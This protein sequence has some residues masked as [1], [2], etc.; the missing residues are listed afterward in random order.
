MLI[1][2]LKWFKGYLLVMI[3]GY[4]PERF[5]NLCR[6][7]NVLIW[8]LKKVEKGYQFHIS[9]MGYRSIR[10]IARKTKTRPMIIERHGLP[11]IVKK[12]LKH[13]GFLI[14]ACFFV[15]ILYTLSLFIWD[16]SLE[17]NYTY[18]EDVIF[19]YLEEMDVY[20]GKQI[21][22]INCKEIE[23]SIRKKYTDIGWVSAEIK[24][25][26][27]RLKIVET[28]MPVPYEKAS[29]PCHLIASHDGIVTSI[30]T[31]Q[32][33]PLVKKGDEVKKGDILVSG[34]VEIVGDNGILIKKEPVI[35]DAD[36][37]IQTNYQYKKSIPIHYQ[38]KDYTEKKRVIYGFSLFHKKLYLYNPFKKLQIDKKYDIITTE[39]NLNLTHS[40]VLPFSFFKKE[41]KEY[42]EVPSV[43]EKE[44]LIEK[45]N[46]YYSQ[47][48]EKLV[49]SGVSVIENHVKIHMDQKNCISAGEVI[50][51]E[52]V[53]ETKRIRETE[54]RIL[55]TD[56]HSGNDD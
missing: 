36:I 51:V 32:G 31:R 17:G 42:Q 56:E 13:K 5:I 53:T 46:M 50:V 54:W 14:G 52:P 2:F 29:K 25:T 38:K 34:I 48:Q 44:I 26:R 10:P 6:N 22:K 20:P 28:N 18:T 3:Y 47:Y 45:A 16:I 49:E 39:N 24:G 4:S 55:E 37:Y 19:Q 1:R 41:Y 11:F 35:A 43:Y 15:I 9:L 27:L 12:Y 30:I 7:H 40:F 23:E 21:S 33:T 8:N